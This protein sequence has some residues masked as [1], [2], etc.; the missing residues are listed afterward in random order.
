MLR[1]ATVATATQGAVLG[2][3]NRQYLRR[4][5]AAAGRRRG[6]QSG[7][8]H[9][10]VYR[11]QHALVLCHGDASR[12]AGSH[13]GAAAAPAR[14]AARPRRCGDLS[15]VE[16]VVRGIILPLRATILLLDCCRGNF[17]YKGLP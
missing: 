6:R 12:P 10:C 7:A 11:D 13:L 1:C 8:V 5:A 3:R 9:L 16:R 14:P 2:L 15:H 4:G 17:H